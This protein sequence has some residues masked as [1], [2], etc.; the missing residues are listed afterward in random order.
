MRRRCTATAHAAAPAGAG[1]TQLS[2]QPHQLTLQSQTV[3]ANPRGYP[4][5][6]RAEV[7]LAGDPGEPQCVGALSRRHWSVRSTPPIS[8]SHPSVVARFLRSSKS[9][10][11]SSRRAQ[12]FRVH[13]QLRG[14]GAH[15]G[16]SSRTGVRRSRVRPCAY[17]N[18]SALVKLITRVVL[19]WFVRSSGTQTDGNI[20]SCRIALR[21]FRRAGTDESPVTR[22]ARPEQTRDSRG[23]GSSAE[24]AME[25]VKAV[26]HSQNVIDRPRRI[27]RSA[28]RRPVRDG[29][30]TANAPRP[31][32]LRP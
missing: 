4:P 21:C 20:R 26:H 19:L 15:A 1:R 31:C 16:S 30:S 29:T 14:P 24:L 28:D 10:S 3:P 27:A 13:M 8:P 7:D 32:P 6:A 23:S 12:H 5:N 17:R 22:R 25:R 11:N 9:D 18:F 2:C